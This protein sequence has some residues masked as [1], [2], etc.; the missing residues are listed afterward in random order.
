MTAR[1][2]TSTEPRTLEIPG[3]PSDIRVRPFDLAADAAAL[4]AFLGDVNVADRNDQV[5]TAEELAIEWRPTPGFEPERDALILEDAAGFV[6]HV[7]VDAQV[8][9]DKVVHWIEG[10]VRQDR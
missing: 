2:S 10:W 4:A 5:L 7:N 1:G 9:G 8:R 3:L 6:A